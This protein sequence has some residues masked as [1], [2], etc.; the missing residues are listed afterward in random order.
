MSS[1]RDL[2]E[3]VSQLRQLITNSPRLHRK[4]V[5]LRYGFSEATLHRW[6]RKGLLPE[7]IRICGP[8]WRLVD[9]EA[10]E[11]AGRLPRPMSA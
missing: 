11:A 10:A 5:M 3:Q 6:M 9:L 8:L 4:D 1:L 7:P 2:A